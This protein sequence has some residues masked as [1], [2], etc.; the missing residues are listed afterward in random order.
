MPPTGSPGDAPFP[1]LWRWHFT[2]CLPALFPTF[3]AV[4]WLLARW[5]RTGA[6][7]AD[8]AR[9][10]CR[11]DRRSDLLL[12][13]FLLLMLAW[14]SIGSWRIPFATFFVALLF[15]KVTLVVVTLYRGYFLVA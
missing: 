5:S 1:G 7:S 8:I 9:A 12:P 10:A 4:H 6:L 15:A 13:L 3:T 14:R 11:W 2:I